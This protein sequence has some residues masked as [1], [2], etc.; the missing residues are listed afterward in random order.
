MIDSVLILWLFWKHFIVDFPLQFPYMFKNKGKYG[1]LGGILH[2]GLHG[3]T[4]LMVVSFFTT[5]SFAFLMALLD[6][7]I[8]YHMDWFKTYSCNVK[9]YTVT[10]NSDQYWLW[11]GLDQYVHAMT[12]IVIAV[13][14]SIY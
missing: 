4:T 1:H 10:T 8:H 14:V 7:V 5:L 11:F 12:Y 13:L 9:N 2:A 3:L 6:I